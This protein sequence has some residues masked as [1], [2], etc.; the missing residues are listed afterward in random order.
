[1]TRILI[2]VLTDLLSMTAIHLTPGLPVTL[3][4]MVEYVPA[5]TLVPRFVLSLRELYA[6][7][8]QGRCG[9]DIDTAFG[10]TSAVSRGAAASTIMFANGGQHEALEQGEEIQMEEREI[11]G[12]GN[13]A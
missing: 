3:H 4:L 12:T 7:D 13:E 2:Y 9:S 1:M 10:L 6:Q 5:I 8:L 11:S